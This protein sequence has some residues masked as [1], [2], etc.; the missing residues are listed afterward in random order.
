MTDTDTPP[1]T[2]G[3]VPTTLLEDYKDERS[4]TDIDSKTEPS[5]E[6]S[7]NT[8]VSSDEND[9]DNTM[10]EPEPPAAETTAG[11]KSHPPLHKTYGPRWSWDAEAKDYIPERGSY[12]YRPPQE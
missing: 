10:K 6:V 4:G 11:S 9:K 7:D 5:S 3:K 2:Q 12:V 1:E 8:H